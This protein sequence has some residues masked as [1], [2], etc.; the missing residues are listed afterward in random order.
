MP[1]NMKPQRAAL[2]AQYL[3]DIKIPQ[4]ADQITAHFKWG[5]S[6]TA[7][8]LPLV[9]AWGILIKDTSRMPYT[10]Q[11][12]KGATINFYPPFEYKDTP[13]KEQAI[14]EPCNSFINQTTRDWT[15]PSRTLGPLLTLCAIYGMGVEEQSQR[16]EYDEWLE[17]IAV[18]LR[19]YYIAYRIVKSIQA[20]PARDRNLSKWGIPNKLKGQDKD[21]TM[22]MSVQFA[23]SFK[24][25]LELIP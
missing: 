11:Y 23:Q 14:Y 2:I 18:K 24:K 10:Y 9:K 25:L 17:A 22:T 21:D 8:S 3:M 13:E 4:T 5:H 15:T 19:Q 16:Q 1:E 12:K 6:G 20:M 7:R